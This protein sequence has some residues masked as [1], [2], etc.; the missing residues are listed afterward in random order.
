MLLLLL[1]LR[2]GAGPLGQSGR[3]GFQSV[4][5]AGDGGEGGR[6]CVKAV[7]HF[8]ESIL[9]VLE[10]L[11][12]LVN[13]SR[14]VLE[15]LGEG[16]LHVDIQL[17]QPRGDALVTRLELSL[18]RGVNALKSLV[19]DALPVLVFG[20]VLGQDLGDLSSFPVSS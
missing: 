6:G 15:E 19:Q 16:L 12:D 17:G 10:A 14:D 7:S 3:R 8:L 1:L 2:A 13:D 4:D 5:A 9:V 18:R 20:R 11:L